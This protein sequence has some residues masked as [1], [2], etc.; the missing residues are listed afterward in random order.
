MSDERNPKNNKSVELRIND[1]G[2]RQAGRILDI[3][4]ASAARLGIGKKV[5]REVSLEVVELGSGKTI[6]QPS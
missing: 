4:P 6:R 5:M 1:R 2:P 3:S